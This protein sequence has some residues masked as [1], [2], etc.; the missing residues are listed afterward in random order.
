MKISEEISYG[1]IVNGI[2]KCPTTTMNIIL[3]TLSFTESESKNEISS[4]FEV[5]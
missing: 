5:W 1:K 3:I 4:T 2:T